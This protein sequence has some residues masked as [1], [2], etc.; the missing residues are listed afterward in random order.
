MAASVYLAS[1]LIMGAL[2]VAALAAS[3][4]SGRRAPVRRGLVDHRGTTSRTPVPDA[5]V[6]TAWILLFLLVA[7]FAGGTTLLFVGGIGAPEAIRNAAGPALA[8]LGGA[9][10]AAFLFAGVYTSGR[11]WGLRRAGATA[12][13]LW[14][15][16]LLFLTAIVL[17]L[18]TAGA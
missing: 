4:R 13:G 9:V 12:A 11:S 1:T 5:G 18:V 17:Q 7:L 8:A 3:A 6:P 14:A 16:A 10:I 2:L 15:A